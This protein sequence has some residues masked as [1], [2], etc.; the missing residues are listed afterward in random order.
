MIAP[1][2]TALGLCACTLLAAPLVAQCT[3]PTPVPGGTF[4]SGDHSQVDSNALSASNFVVSAS[5]TATF[6]AGN[7]IQ[8]LPGFHATAGSVP[9]TFHAWVD[10]APTAVSM[11][12]SA[13]SGQTQPFTG[14]VSSPSG[15]SNLAHV[16]ALFNTTSASTTNACYI[17]YDPVSNL[18]YLADD[19]SA[20]WLGGFAPGSTGTAGNS[21]CSISGTGASFG[22]SG[23]Q[24]S[25]TVPVTFTTSFSG[26]KNE[27]L[28]ALDSSGVYTGWQQMGQWTVP[29]TYSLI[30][31][32]GG[33]QLSFNGTL[34]IS[35]CSLQ[36]VPG[37]ALTIGAPSPQAPYVFAS[38]S[39]GLAISHSI[40]APASAATYTATFVAETVSQPSLSGGPTNA[41]ANTGTAYT[42]TTSSSKSNLG[43]TLQY[44]FN[45]G[46]GTTSGW[47][48]SN[49]A[50]KTWTAA[51]TFLVTVQARCAVDTTIT[52]ATSAP[53]A[54]SVV[55]PDFGISVSPP[56]WNGAGGSPTVFVT[57]TSGF[58]G[59]VS[60][61]ATCPTCSGLVPTV[62]FNLSTL[63]NSASWATTMIVQAPRVNGV[64]QTGAWDIVVTGYGPTSTH[65][66]TFHFVYAPPQD[67]TM[68]VQPPTALISA[69][70]SGTYSVTVNAVNGLD[71]GT[72]L[73]VSFSSLPAGATASPASLTLNADGSVHYFS[74][75]TSA[76][77]TSGSF[78]VTGIRSGGGGHSISVPLQVT[79]SLNHP[80]SLS[81]VTPNGG[82]GSGPLTFQFVYTDA[83][84]ATA[85]RTLSARFT[86]N[87][88]NAAACSFQYDR[89]SGT[90]QLYNDAGTALSTTLSNTQCTLPLPSGSPNGNNFTLS[91]PITFT[92][93][94]LGTKEIDMQA[95]DTSSSYVGWS[96]MGSW[97]IPSPT[98]LGLDQM[99]GLD[100][101]IWRHQWMTGSGGTPLNGGPYGLPDNE[102]SLVNSLVSS[103][104]QQ[105]SQLDLQAS[106]YSD[107]Y[108]YMNA[109]KAV[110]QSFQ[111]QLQSAVSPPSWGTL[112]GYIN[113]GLIPRMAALSLDSGLPPSVLQRNPSPSSACNPSAINCLYTW[114]E[115]N[116]YNGGGNNYGLGAQL[117]SWVEG[118]NQLTYFSK[119]SGAKETFTPVGG[120]AATDCSTPSG[121]GTSV[122]R[123]WTDQTS[124]AGGKAYDP[125]TVNQPSRGTYT[126][127]GF[128]AFANPTIN[129]AVPPFLDFTPETPPL[130]PAI[131]TFTESNGA[132]D[133]QTP[134]DLT[135]NVNGTI[136]STGSTAVITSCS[137]PISVQALLTPPLPVGNQAPPITW[138][139][140][141]SVDNLHRTV[142]CQAGTV[143][144]TAAIGANLQTTVT[145][146]VQPS[147][148][149]DQTKVVTG[150]GSQFTLTGTTTVSGNGTFTWEA[151]AT[152]PGDDTTI[153]SPP[154]PLPNCNNQPTCAIDI[155]A[156][157]NG[158][159]ATVRVHY[160]SGTGDVTA[161]TRVIVVQVSR[162]DVTIPASVG[163]NP[164]SQVSPPPQIASY[165]AQLSPGA[166]QWPTTS[167]PLWIASSP[168]VL[169]RNTASVVWLSATTV[170]P[171]TDPDVTLA[172]GVVRAPDDSG[173]IGSPQ[174]V[175][176]LSVGASGAATLALNQRGSFQVFAYVDSNGN[177]QRDINETGISFPLVM[178][179]ALFVNNLSQPNPANLDY[180]PGTAGG[181]AAIITGSYNLDA[182][183]VAGVYLVANV[184][185]VGGGSDGRRGVCT[186]LDANGV[187]TAWRVF[188]R[189]VQDIETDSSDA[190][191]GVAPN[192]HYFAWRPVVSSSQATASSKFGDRPMF[193]PAD[194]PPLLLPL[195]LL[196]APPPP[197]ASA[198]TGGDSSSMGPQLTRQVAGQTLAYG[199]R[200]QV[201]AVDSP[202]ATYPMV[203]PAATFG[204]PPI[205][206]CEMNTSFRSFLIVWASGVN[207]SAPSNSPPDRLYG[208]VL[209]QPWNVVSAYQV[210]ANGSAQDIGSPTIN[211]DPN[212]AT[213]YPSAV[214][215]TAPEPILIPPVII[216][217][218][219]AI[220]NR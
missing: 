91:V 3:N 145:V 216:S 21:Q 64:Y 11:A 74:V 50:S 153:V 205:V 191:Y 34:C 43:H 97:T 176:S 54:T 195:P 88:T 101:F 174:N 196:D 44:L 66:A 24:L 136:Y 14:T 121:S 87:G 185:F 47:Q 46:D 181:A 150:A 132:D 16:F 19:A 148:S 90:M 75:A 70:Q 106:S 128:H 81:S 162:V 218:L 30:S 18:L 207:N 105:I 53:I 92:N 68:N 7:C 203:H 144:I 15:N 192:L 39:D 201:R 215:L 147:L 197:V 168:L 93:W 206:Q 175:P 119:L 189:W 20:N 55:T 172:F 154:A 157:A 110:L 163:G 51:G 58:Y 141:T 170:P 164:P 211:L 130:P 78:T 62:S 184:D 123:T 113:N 65:T 28:F 35:P 69:G 25:V 199:Q 2:R 117:L 209:S 27:Y 186:Q 171:P 155:Q 149:V 26:V 142:P 57:P 52:S 116:F 63:P 127:C 71:P 159:K 213:F 33:L 40:A 94:F 179:E 182:P 31:V 112:S 138:T 13:G 12:P 151:L 60:L 214:S 85:L 194:P 177:G 129:Q 190:T 139:N 158:G 89:A 220:A 98:S 109:R 210:A 107:G 84:G 108:V 146:Q 41:S 95:V 86:S 5:A 169:I 111:A 131:E 133:Y 99:A 29:S 82:S 166:I 36:A 219:T 6:T 45:W 38:W 217:A 204:N 167:D 77:T 49:S 183:S 188:G 165:S 72:S 42:F 212:A 135:L 124:S 102:T 61:G 104:A 134:V 208:L 202:G 173:S 73:T 48:S 1:L 8:L 120:N 22:T 83:D 200:F 32:P 4:T 140:G 160:R 118:P 37:T 100:L 76:S 114:S 143:A 67:F 161:D 96:P 152:Q 156:S 122:I 198:G 17:H 80:P 23:T 187:C 178:V 126:L 10:M 115:I 103:A 125:N 59:P 56:D 180:V 193:M 9:T 137:A 79:P